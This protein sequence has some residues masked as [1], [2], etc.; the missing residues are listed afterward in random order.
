MRANLEATNGLIMAEAVQMALG[1]KLGRLAAHDLVEAA[2]KR[3]VREGRHLREVLG[4]DPGVRAQL[5][6]HALAAL[7][8]PTSYLGVAGALVDRV[9][10]KR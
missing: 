4:E 8:E 1:Q 2:C 5:D 7:F 10:A 3:A 9:Q 6:E